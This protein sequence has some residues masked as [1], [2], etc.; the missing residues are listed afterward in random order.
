VWTLE[1]YRRL[2]HAE[3][4]I[5]AAFPALRA[6]DLV[7]AWSF[8]AD[9]GDEI[10]RQIRENEEAWRLVL[11]FADD[12]FAC[13]NVEAKATAAQQELRPPKTLDVELGRPSPP[14]TTDGR[15]GDFGFYLRAI[16]ESALTLFESTSPSTCHG[17]ACR[18]HCSHTSINCSVMAV[19]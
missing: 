9:H 8:V 7:N 18:Y 11:L 10:D 4:Q 3:A 6:T 12:N 2:G 5:L 15:L 19:E 16:L 1:H 17:W 13:P 14:G